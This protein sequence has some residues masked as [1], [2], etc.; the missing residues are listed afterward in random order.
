MDRDSL[1]SSF[2]F[3]AVVGT[4]V[5][6]VALLMAVVTEGWSA[7]A[8]GPLGAAVLGAAIVGAIVG[9]TAGGIYHMFGVLWE[10][11]T[12]PRPLDEPWNGPVERC[13]RSA[14]TVTKLLD[15]LPDSA[16]ADWLAQIAGTMATKL[17]E[18][19]A[20]AE[21]GRAVAPAINANGIALA[22]RH[23][24]YAQLKRSADE[25]AEVADQVSKLMIELQTPGN[26]E[27]VRTELQVLTEQLPLLRPAT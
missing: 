26:M 7:E 15:T 12:K 11:P 16:A 14:S 25:F 23:P 27:R 5:M 22:K 17:A 20:F 8:D 6:L 19:E 24:L 21:A 13:A 3:G 1:S 18:M 2:R 4:F 9:C 10:K